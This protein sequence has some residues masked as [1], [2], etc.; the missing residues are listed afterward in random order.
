MFFVSLCYE[1]TDNRMA[2]TLLRRYFWLINTIRSFGPISYEQINEYWQRSR[3]NEYG[4]DLPKKT[5]RNHLE[6]IQE[7]FDLEIHCERKGGYKYSI[8]E[9]GQQD[10]WMSNFLD[11]L[12]IQTAIGEDPKMKDRIID[13]DVKY[14]PVLPVM[15]Q[16]IKLRA[17]IRFRVFISYEEERKD[18]SMSDYEDIDYSYRYYCPLGML[19]VSDH[20]YAIG[21]FSNKSKLAG[22]YGVFRIHDMTD[23]QAMIGEEMENYPE[24][25]SLK[26]F[27]QDFKPNLKDTFF[28][29]DVLL[30]SDLQ[31][32][33]LTEI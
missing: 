25:F 32:R 23:I 7:I 27:I 3:L 8:V 13:Y 28:N 33:E 12:S 10:R 15:A 4:E 19:Q 30:F 1:N 6:A 16:F 18:P 26:A 5:F 29:Q 2:N 20:W 9:E 31:C 21:V 14:N 22:K 11:T 24:N 17:V